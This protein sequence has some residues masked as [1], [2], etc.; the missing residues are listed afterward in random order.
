MVSINLEWRNLEFSLYA[1][2]I[3]TKNNLSRQFILY[4]QCPI[5]NAQISKLTLPVPN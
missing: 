2:I 1:K 3:L 5:L 4:A